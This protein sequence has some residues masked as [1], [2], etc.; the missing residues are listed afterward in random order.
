MDMIRYPDW[1]EQALRQE[2]TTLAQ[3]AGWTYEYARQQLE[4]VCALELEQ[5]T[6]KEQVA[7]HLCNLFK[8]N[9]S[10]ILP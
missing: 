2:A 1:I 4:R 8:V 3:Q 9:N 10:S 5:A 6:Q 7:H